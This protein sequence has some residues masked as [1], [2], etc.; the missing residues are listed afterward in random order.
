MPGRHSESSR[1][2]L[3][4]KAATGH[5]RGRRDCTGVR[6]EPREP[7]GFPCSPEDLQGL[8]RLHSRL[9]RPAQ[10]SESSRASLEDFCAGLFSRLCQLV[11]RTIF[12]PY[13]S[14][15]RYTRLFTRTIRDIP[16]E[17]R[18]RSYQFLLRAGYVRSLGSGLYSYL[19]LG[20]RVVQR[21]QEIIEEELAPLGAQQIHVPLVN[22]YELWKKSRRSL[23]VNEDMIRFSDRFGRELV[24]APTHEEAVVELVRSSLSSYR[25]L[26]VFVYQFQTKFRDEERVRFGLV[27]TREFIMKDAYSFHV[28]FSD[29]NN[30]LPKVFNAYERIFRRCG[31]E[32]V[33]AEAGVGYMGGDK[34]YEFLMPWPAGDDSVIVCKYCGYRANTE[35]AVAAKEPTPGRPLPMERVE[36]PGARTMERLAAF[37]GKP[38]PSLTKSMVYAGLTSLVMAVVR[39][40]QE[41]SLEKLGRLAG[42]PILRLARRDEMEA[43]GLTPGYT[44]PIGFDRELMALDAGIKIFVDETVA[45]SAN[46]VYGA[47]EEGYHF[48]N[49]NFGRDYDAD[50]VGDITRVVSGATCF[51]C[52]SRLSQLRAMELGNIFRLG[53]Y[54]TRRM[55][56]SVQVERGGR[57]YPQMGSYGIGVGR[58]LA[59]IVEANCDD[60]GI[61]W[62]HGLSPYDGYLMS[63]GNS[64]K[65]KAAVEA[66]Y[67]ELSDRLLFDDRHESIGRKFKD[68][69]LLGIPYRIVV[70]AEC[71]QEDKV[72]VYCRRTGETREV[73]TAE[74]ANVLCEA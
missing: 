16:S 18:S 65:V 20:W 60:E 37:L 11:D 2:N 63:I 73:G 57:V 69:A 38:K 4:T 15:V 70:S 52:G 3:P 48:L 58:L 29:L 44:S 36:T 23:L 30:F 54:Y 64:P 9:R 32:V 19:P 13:T 40:D 22:P 41:V 12:G 26:P 62:P 14:N 68:A 43:V 50:K 17:V 55:D 71:L 59:A 67:R 33:A 8:T 31:V 51:H 42:E 25:E 66:I 21:I 47:N 45:D 10:E 6:V 27:R 7:R 5:A 1:A 61:C 72:E 39:G 74:I 53:D 35:V 49:G 56:F 34:S 46:L 24:L 28:S